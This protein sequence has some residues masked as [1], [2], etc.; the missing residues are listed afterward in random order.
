VM[1]LVFGDFLLSVSGV[2]RASS[3]VPQKKECPEAPKSAFRCAIVYNDEADYRSLGGDA[4]KF[5]VVEV[6]LD[7][8]SF[9]ED[10]LRQLFALLSK[11]FP[12]SGRLFLHVHTNLED[13]Y[14]PQE[15]EQIPSP[16]GCDI[17]PG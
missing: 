17:L 16:I 3:L 14:T 12:T 7:S 15:A 6:L 11:R 9:S 2:V 8:N 1:M 10:T 4:G 5:R 13:V